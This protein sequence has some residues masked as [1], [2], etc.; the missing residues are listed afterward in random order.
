MTTKFRFPGHVCTLNGQDEFDKCIQTKNR[1]CRFF[2]INYTVS[3]VG[4]EAMEH[5]KSRVSIVWLS[6]IPSER[7]L[8]QFLCQ[9]D[10][11]AERGD[12]T[13]AKVSIRNPSIFSDKKFLGNFHDNYLPSVASDDTNAIPAGC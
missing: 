8:I 9:T 10:G 3:S 13:L 12:A 7:P 1:F 6:L 5:L 4:L 11:Y 2:L